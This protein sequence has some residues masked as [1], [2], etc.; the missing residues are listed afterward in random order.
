MSS[1][2]TPSANRL[3]AEPICKREFFF[4]R[5][6]M[7]PVVAKDLLDRARKGL[8]TVLDVRPAEELL[9]KKGHKARRLE[10]GL[11]EWRLAGLP[12]ERG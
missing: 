4:S 1:N 7:E 9:R 5:D 8:V 10:N 11:A 3:S 2:L 12:V 6:Q